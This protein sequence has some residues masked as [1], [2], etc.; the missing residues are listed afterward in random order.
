MNFVRKF[1]VLSKTFFQPLCKEDFCSNTLDPHE[2]FCSNILDAK[3]E[4]YSDILGAKQD[5][6]SNML[7]VKQDLWSKLRDLK[8]IFVQT[9]FLY[10]AKLLFKHVGCEAKVLINN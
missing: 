7:D 9:F 8:K 1:L 4:C 3:E 6:C 5:F 2:D 10:K